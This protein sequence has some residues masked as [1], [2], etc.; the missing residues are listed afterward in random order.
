M[1]LRR[2][3]EGSENGINEECPQNTDLSVLQEGHTLDHLM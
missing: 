1:K 3:A 2:T